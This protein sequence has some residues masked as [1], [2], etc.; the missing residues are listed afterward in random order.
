MLWRAVVAGLV[1]A[2]VAEL[3]GRFPRV[4]ALVMTLPI[5][6]IVAFVSVWQKEQDVT[7]VAR[8]AR[9]TLVL[10]PLGLPVFLPLAFAERW[11]LSFWSAL[12]LG[13]VLA[14]GTIGIWSA[15][16]PNPTE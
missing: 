15:F 12:S 5:I 8:L 3:A 2:C 1:V 16:G 9:E 4:G 10:V 13:V 14:S 7:T 6:S 11:G